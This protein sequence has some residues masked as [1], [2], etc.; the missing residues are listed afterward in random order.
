MTQDNDGNTILHHLDYL[1][2]DGELFK[3]L[4]EIV[5]KNPELLQ[6]P[7]RK[8][9]TFFHSTLILENFDLID[10]LLEMGADP[11]QPDS[12]GDTA[13]HHLAKHLPKGWR[14]PHRLEQQAQLKR[15]LEA[16][17]DINS[18]NHDG[19]TP[20]FKYIQNGMQA[21]HHDFD[22]GFEQEGMI[23]QRQ[24]S[25]FLKRQEPT[26]SHETMQV[27]HCCI[28]WH[29]RQASGP[30]RNAHTISSGDSRF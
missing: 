3:I 11:L 23:P 14:S 25:T 28:Y 13:L 22:N 1:D 10:A 26:F 24:S 29:P 9:E 20:L 2:G 4:K 12:K 6:L 18:R 30:M 15:L 16:G 21:A 5:V 19:D 27:P 7:N 17:V 8:G